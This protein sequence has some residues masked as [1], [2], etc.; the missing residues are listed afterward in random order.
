M[1]KI[2]LA[3]SGGLDTSFCVPYLKKKY[4]C[5]VHTVTVDCLGM[6]S[7][8]KDKLEEKSLALG[9]DSHAT[10]DGT[11]L[12][13]SKIIAYLIKGNVL[14]DRTYP[15]SVGAERFI[16]AMLIAEYAKNIGADAVAH[17]STGA[18][19]DQVRF[20][21]A[22]RVVNPDMQI[23]TPIRE[24]KFTREQQIKILKEGGFVP[25]DRDGSKA[26]YSINAGIWGTTIGGY[27]TLTPNKA[28]P[29]EAFPELKAPH[30]FNDEA[31]EFS[32][33]FEQGLPVAVN[34]E[35][36]TPLNL[37]Q[38]IKKA[39]VEH[40]IG[41]GMHTGDTI[42]GIKGRIGFEAP[43]ATLVYTAHRELEKQILTK[44]QRHLK[45]TL[46]DYYG[47]LLHEAQY[48]DPVMR[49]I[50][51]FLDATQERVDGTTNLYLYRGNAFPLG[52]ESPNSLM[53]GKAQYGESSQL[54]N[55]EEARAFSKI[56]GIASILSNKQ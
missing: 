2:V 53:N 24:E 1:N 37:L 42:L 10:L 38:S 16:Q 21:V 40:G 14:R 48:F 11:D 47:M 41:R 36:D 33:T 17:G 49:N 31:E 18:G 27:E 56:Y 3:F 6:T 34:G 13:Y 22:L 51:A 7:E 5:E 4:D 55:G 25:M 50:E 43:V 39:A 19:N 23:I 20:D 9:A 28:L 35:S 8:Q 46:S 26:P 15:L 45:D 52:V 29:P 12:I 54:W 30:L 32:I 44:W